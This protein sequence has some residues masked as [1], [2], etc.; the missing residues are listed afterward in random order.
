VG[1][2]L[3]ASETEVRFLGFG[4]YVGD[5]LFHFTVNGEEFPAPSPKLVLD[6]GTVVFGFECWWGPEKNIQEFL[7]GKT[8]VPVDKEGVLLPE[9]N[10][11]T[12]PS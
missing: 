8:V 9:K 7:K 6:D 5:Q 2:I 12:T 1:A 11:P 10:A 3:S 4:V